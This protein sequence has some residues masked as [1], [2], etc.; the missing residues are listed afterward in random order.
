MFSICDSS[1]VPKFVKWIYGRK[2][3]HYCGSDIFIDVVRARKHRM[4]F[5]GTKQNVLD[6][7]QQNLLKENPDVAGMTFKELPFCTVDEFD[8]KGI[9]RMIEEDGADII[10]VALGAPK[11]EIFMNRLQPHLKKGVMIAIGAAFNFYSGLSDAPQRCPAWMRKMHLEFVHRI[12]KEPKKQIKRC[13]SI[14]V[15]L[16]KILYREYKVKKNQK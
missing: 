15:T 5:L 6:A 13:W 10:S 1:W 8:Y 11:Q 2:R 16:P 7:L 4:I 12:F 3:S 14:V 9:A